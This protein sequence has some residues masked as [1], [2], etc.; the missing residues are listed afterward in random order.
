MSAELTKETYRQAFD[1][2]PIGLF[3]LDDKL[4]IKAWN[5]WLI[6]ATNTS[7]EDAI[8]TQITSLFPDTKNPRFEWAVEY[9]IKNKAQQILSQA[10]NHYLIPIKLSRL[11]F[12]TDVIFMQQHVQISP[13]D[14]SKK[15]FALVSIIDVTEKVVRENALSK[16]ALEL[17]NESNRDALTDAYNRRYMYLWLREKMREAFAANVPIS[18][19]MIDLDFFKKINDEHGHNT[20]DAVLKS[21][22]ET[23]Q[24]G[25]RPKDILIRYGG[26]E[27]IILM[28][29]LN[30]K[31]STHIAER[32]R[33][34]ISETT[35]PCLQ[36][37]DITCSI[38]VA[39]WHPDHPCKIEELLKEADDRLY[40]AK[41]QGRNQVQD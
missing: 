35:F 8:G 15:T 14:I 23:L 13:V 29:N 38:G 3:I 21:F 16:M 33:Q 34:K 20:G 37:Q 17:E 1:F 22:S 2:S 7:A 32:L 6:D 5:H 12:D 9:A 18:C 25:L 39:T 10:L 40:Q 31:Q 41:E 24:S 4:T 36:K 27:F 19:L 26:E 11:A 28:P 30:K